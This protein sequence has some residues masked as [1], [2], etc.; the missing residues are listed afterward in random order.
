MKDF[1]TFTEENADAEPNNTRKGV[2]NFI[3]TNL[4]R[5]INAPG[6]DDKS[7]LLLIAALAVLSNNEDPQSVQ[8]ARRMAQA[9]LQRSGKTKKGK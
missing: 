9:A 1:R 8:V 3:T 7:L 2:T 4:F 6:E 5:F